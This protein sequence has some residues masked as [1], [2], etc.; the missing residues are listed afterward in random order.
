MADL[1]A[2]IDNLEAAIDAQTWRLTVR[3]GGILI[4]GFVAAGLLICGAIPFLA[5]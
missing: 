3:L 2:A 5:P 1:M 4:G